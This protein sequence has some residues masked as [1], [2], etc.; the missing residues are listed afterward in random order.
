MYEK[1]TTALKLADEVLQA[2]SSKDDQ[3]SRHAK[4]DELFDYI[5]VN[6]QIPDSAGFTVRS[7]VRD[8]QH[9]YDLCKP[10]INRTYPSPSKE[11]GELIRSIPPVILE[12][13][14]PVA[15]VRFLLRDGRIMCSHHS[16]GFVKF[17][18]RYG[19]MILSCQGG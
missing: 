7:N 18:N 16:K 4:W 2:S 13:V 10:F 11:L 3:K 15:I 6:F 8:Y 9:E 1:Y 12:V 17:A 14:W 5:H 19:T